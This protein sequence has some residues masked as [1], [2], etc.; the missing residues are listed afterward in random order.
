MRPTSQ[1]K[2]A[3]KLTQQTVR[4]HILIQKRVQQ[5]AAIWRAIEMRLKHYFGPALRRNDLLAAA[6][7][8]KTL[9]L[10]R[11]AK[12]SRICICCWFCEHW[13]E[14]EPMLAAKFIPRIYGQARRLRP[15]DEP[16]RLFLEE[17]LV[18][19]VADNDEPSELDEGHPLLWPDVDDW[20]DVSQV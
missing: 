2:Q 15:D 7:K 14:I 8:I 4:D 16:V 1:L 19:E 18:A 17:Q 5:N 13:S 12:R 11:L 20:T 3:Q 9:K 6:L 10:D